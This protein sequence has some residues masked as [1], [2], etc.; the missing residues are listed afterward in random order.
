MCILYV[1]NNSNNI[2]I[3]TIYMCVHIVHSY[4]IVYLY[5]YIGIPFLGE[6]NIT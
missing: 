5:S 2:I 3:I 4:I 6:F 1:F